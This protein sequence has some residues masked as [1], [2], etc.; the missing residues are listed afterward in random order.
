M[1]ANMLHYHNPKTGLEGKFCQEYCL[2]L[3]LMHGRVSIGHFSDERVSNS[4]IKKLIEK[5]TVEFKDFAKELGEHTFPAEVTI[6][7]NSGEKYHCRID[8]SK[9]SPD[10]PMSLIELE[11]KYREC[12]SYVLSDTKIGQSMELIESLESCS[13]LDILMNWLS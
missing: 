10:N 1:V 4:N 6:V 7:M 5:T 13:S 11:K 2:A 3:A 8:N 12:A 9:G